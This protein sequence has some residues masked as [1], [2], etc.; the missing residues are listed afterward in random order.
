MAESLIEVADLQRLSPGIDAERAAA[1]A[2]HA[3]A[4]ALS[5]A[6]CIGEPGFDNHAALKAILVAAAL[7]WESAPI[8]QAV[9]TMT[10]GPFS[11][12][13]DTTSS[14]RMVFFPSEITALQK[15]CTVAG[16]GKA[17]HVNLGGW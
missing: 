16:A 15:L 13:I 2:E 14:R 3:S 17:F 7:R 6:P 12:G 9:T 10:A 1:F 4:L 5:V 8:D 11:R